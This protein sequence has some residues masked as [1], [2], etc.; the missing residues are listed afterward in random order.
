MQRRGNI[1]PKKQIHHEASS[2]RRLA[3]GFKSDQFLK[4]N[5]R[6]RIT[7]PKLLNKVKNIL[8]STNGNSLETTWKKKEKAM[9]RIDPKTGKIWYDRTLADWNPSHFRLF[10]GNIGEDV[11]EKLLVETFIKYGSLSKVKIPRDTH[12][13]R[14]LIPMII[15]D[16][17]KEMNGKYVGNKPIVLQRAK[18]E[19]GEVVTGHRKGNKE[20]FVK[21]KKHKNHRGHK[22]DKK[23]LLV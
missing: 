5:N 22:K 12:L 20:I 4:S 13:Y 1:R 18:T 10:V 17:T 8:D 21:G 2:D 19:L 15:Y 7:D 14:L 6:R 16:A 23:K 3:S 9:E 11:T